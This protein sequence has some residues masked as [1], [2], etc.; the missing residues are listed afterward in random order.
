MSSYKTKRT[1]VLKTFGWF[2][3]TA[4]LQF[5]WQGSAFA[6][7]I[8]WVITSGS[9]TSGGNVNAQADFTRSNGSLTVALTNFQANPTADSQAISGIT[10][11]VIGASGSGSLTTVNL[12]YISTIDTDTNAYTAGVSD[13]LVRWKASEIGT[14]IRLTTLTGGQP[15][16][17]IIGPDNQGGFDPNVGQYTNANPSVSNHNPSVLGTASFTI[18]VPG[19]T[20]SSQIGNVV[21]QFGTATTPE[22]VPGVPV[23]EPAAFIGLLGAGL[24]VFARKILRSVSVY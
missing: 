14:A 17:L 4:L 19:T 23:P 18:T 22:S 2:A 21:F 24:T 13:S 11:S 5:V 10:F 7:P 16:R 1:V 3:A 15:D 8:S 6:D 12:G 20:T 9:T